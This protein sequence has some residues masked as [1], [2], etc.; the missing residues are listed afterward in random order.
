MAKEKAESDG[1]GWF[2]RWRE[3]RARNKLRATE[4]GVVRTM[5]APKMRSGSRGTVEVLVVAERHVR[6]ARKK[7]GRAT[8]RWGYTR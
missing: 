7:S 5:H 8:L 1:R 6:Q 2:A 3:R 4:W